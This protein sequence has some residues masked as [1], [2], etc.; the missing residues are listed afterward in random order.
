VGDVEGTLQVDLDDPIP[1]LNLVGIV[2]FGS[3]ANPR[4]VNEDVRWSVLLD[5]VSGK[6]RGIVALCHIEFLAPRRA[7]ASLDLA[8]S[9]ADP[10]SRSDT[11]TFAPSAAKSRAVEAPIPLPH[12]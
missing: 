10:L 9:S 6:C 8:T 2:K 5:H 1:D 3:R 4:I 11:I 7:S 12:L